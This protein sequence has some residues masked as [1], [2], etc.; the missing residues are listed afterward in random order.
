MKK[1]LVLY[2]GGKAPSTPQEGEASMKEW[3]AWFGKLGSAVVEAGAPVGGSKVVNGA[4][5]QDGAG[6]NIS[7]GYSVLQADDLAGAAKI[8]KSCPIIADGGTVHVFELM[9]M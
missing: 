4:G 6:G 1:F 2:S 5:V 7:N 3:R 9:A 8:L